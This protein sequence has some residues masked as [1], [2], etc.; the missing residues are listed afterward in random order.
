MRTALVWLLALL[1][2]G[3][4][5]SGEVGESAAPG[6][7]LLTLERLLAA[8]SLAGTSPRAPTWSPDS[9]RLAFLWDD[10][11]RPAREVWLVEADGTGLRR[12]TDPVEGA[13]G[14]GE[15]AW[16]PDGGGLVFLRSGHLWHSDLDG[17]TRRLTEAAGPRSDLAVSPD[18]RLASF[19]EDGDLWLLDLDS[20][21]LRRLTRV[22]V[23]SLSEVT[24][25]R[26]ARREVEIGPYVWGG[27]TYAW[28]PDGRTIA[29]HHVDRRGM[30]QVP[31]PDYLGEETRPN[32]VRRS[33][34]GDPNSARRVGLVSV[35]D[36]ALT[37]LDLPDP[38]A[39]R[40]VDFAWS[41]D[42]RLLVDQEADTAVDRWLH[43]VDGDS[44]QVRRL[45]HDRRESRVY[46]ACGSA[47][48]PDGQGVLFLGDLADRYGLYLLAPGDDEPRLLSDP[49]GDVLGPP[50]VARDGGVAIF[51][52]NLASPAERHAYR[53]DPDG[54]VTR[55]TR[56]PGHHQA[57]PAPDGRSVALLHSSDGRPTELFL[58]DGRGATPEV[59]ITRSP[60]PAFDEHAWARVR[61][62]T[63]PDRSGAQL[64]HARILEPPELEPGRRYPV[65]FGPMY[66]NTVRNRWAGRWALLQE[67]LV[68]RGYLVVQ[69]D[70]R[71]STGYGRAFRE[72]FLGDFAGQ[73]LDD[74]ESAVAF[75]ETLPHVDPDRIGVWGSSYGGT[76]TLYALLKKPGLFQAGVAAA[77]AVDPFFFG[78]DDVAIVRRPD[79]LPEAFLRGAAQYADQ[80]QDDLLIIHGMQDQVVPFKTAVV[81]AEA[82]IRAGKDFDFAFAPAGTHGWA[83]P[84]RYARFLYGK[85]LGHFDRSLAPGADQPDARTEPPPPGAPR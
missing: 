10:A 31:F 44:G 34:P 17:R 8:P 70:V 42:G 79:D 72:A 27:P 40:V 78:G 20:G 50:R 1:V 57:F 13:G 19:L 69:V 36:G 18:G 54:T 74:L 45:W 23:P 60:P 66:S 75:V 12:L 37:L 29:V 49:A 68:A 33:Y 77:A 7:T 71:G 11:A 35:D 81:L 46:T 48:A 53:L 5:A 4:A 30:G 14:V 51:P 21:A 43:L 32:P 64:L 39:T 76:L 55:L 65:L 62:V 83:G 82:L 2:G 28:A 24:L 15:L 56:R 73:D 58:V 3:C 67:L 47:W 6:K 38:T 9:A 63:F 59:P 25:G 16:L 22:A 85:L 41:P 80:L 52:S 26:Y 61:Y 84:P